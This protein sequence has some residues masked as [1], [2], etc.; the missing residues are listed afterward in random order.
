[1]LKQC[2]TNREP[3][4]KVKNKTSSAADKIIYGKMQIDKSIDRR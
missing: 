4:L 1:M 3:N 2:L